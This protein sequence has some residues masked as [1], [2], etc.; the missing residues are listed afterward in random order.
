MDSLTGNYAFS[1][2]G[3]PRYYNRVKPD[4]TTRSKIPSDDY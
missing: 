1:L 3:L 2:L 4:A